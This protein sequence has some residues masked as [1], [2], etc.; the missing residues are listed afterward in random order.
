MGESKLVV[1]FGKTGSCREEYNLKVNQ[2]N[3]K[4][5]YTVRQSPGSGFHILL[6]KRHIK[7]Y[8]LKLLKYNEIVLS[9]EQ[10]AGGEIIVSYV[11]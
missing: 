3:T 6:D 2:F 5:F 7:Y 10:N 4:L 1:V 9:G 8:S 11:K